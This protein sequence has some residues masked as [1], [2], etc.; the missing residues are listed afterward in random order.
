MAL[1]CLGLAAT[2]LQRANHPPWRRPGGSRLQRGGLLPSWPKP[3]P[4]V[5]SYSTTPNLLTYPHSHRHPAKGETTVH[6]HLLPSLTPGWRALAI[7]F[8]IIAILALVAACGGD[9][10]TPTPTPATVAATP[11]PT[12]TA[13]ATPAPTPAPTPT[14]TPE[15]M[16]SPTAPAM[17]AMQQNTHP[18]AP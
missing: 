5:C 4:R 13:T 10:P 7:A 1:K 8:V 17:P 16:P 18:W 9:D 12:P 6:R 11:A 14:P 15:A 3:V 2:P